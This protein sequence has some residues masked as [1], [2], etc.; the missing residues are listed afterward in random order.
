MSASKTFAAGPP[1]GK[2]PWCAIYLTYQVVTTFLLRVPLW[3]LYLALPHNRPK[4]TWTLKRAF[5]LRLLKHVM[6]VSYMY[7]LT[8][9]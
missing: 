9:L 3:V 2:Q 1:Y 5:M 8:L 7:A 4:W 6:H